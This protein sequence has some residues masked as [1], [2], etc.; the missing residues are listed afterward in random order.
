MRWPTTMITGKRRSNFALKGN[1]GRLAGNIYRC[2][3]A[4]PRSDVLVF[5]MTSNHNWK[6]SARH[7]YSKGADVRGSSPTLRTR[8]RYLYDWTIWL[9]E[10]KNLTA[11]YIQPP[12]IRHPPGRV[13]PSA[14]IFLFGSLFRF[15]YVKLSTIPGRSIQSRYT[16]GVL[17][18]FS[19]TGNRFDGN[20]MP[21]KV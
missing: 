12:S 8:V 17:S 21:Y 14:F 13:L 7:L 20:N 4:G 11:L 19:R 5:D 2:L 10:G 15:R 18:D 6:C 16:R 9:Y 1:F 3:I